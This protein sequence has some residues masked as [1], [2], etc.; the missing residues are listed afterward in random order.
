M[1]RR[2]R[3]PP[4]GIPESITAA[5]AFQ[6][7]VDNI[8]NKAQ[9]PDGSRMSEAKARGFV[10][11]VLAFL[12]YAGQ[13]EVLNAQV[14]PEG[15]RRA[16]TC[17]LY[18]FRDTPIGD[19]VL[20]AGP[21][22]VPRFVKLSALQREAPSGSIY[23]IAAADTSGNATQAVKTAGRLARQVGRRQAQAAE[24]AKP[25]GTRAER[26]KRR[27][28]RAPPRPTT[29]APAPAAPAPAPAPAAAAAAEDE[30]MGKVGEDVAK[31]KALFGL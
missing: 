11:R 19:V 3:N 22:L 7:I 20:A 24:A 6:A 29:P 5:D 12:G 16:T 13:P 28:R 14:R 30:E 31:L 10:Q 1:A 23:T 18:V 4:I 2:R 8:D 21:T 15:S 17:R 27:R 26:P 9:A 25:V